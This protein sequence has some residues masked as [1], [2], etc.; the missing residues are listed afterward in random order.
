MRKALSWRNIKVTPSLATR[1]LSRNYPL[2]P[3]SMTLVKRN[4]RWK[5]PTLIGNSNFLKVMSSRLCACAQREVPVYKHWPNMTYFEFFSNW[6][7]LYAIC[8]C[9]KPK[10]VWLLSYWFVVYKFR[11]LEC[12][13]NVRYMKRYISKLRWKAQCRTSLPYFDHHSCK[14]YDGS[15]KLLYCHKYERCKTSRNVFP[16]QTVLNSPID[17]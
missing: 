8:G 6:T 16:G 12:E 7:L 2:Q 17:G 10:K 14:S 9:T 4:K 1:K 13:R 11:S 15:S 3:S 5:F